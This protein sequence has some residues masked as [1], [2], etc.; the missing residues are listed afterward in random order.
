MTL[1]SSASIGDE[2]S[3][4]DYANSFDTYALT[5]GRNSHNIEGAAAD[6]TISVEG[7]GN[8]LVYVDSTKGWLLRNK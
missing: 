6:L 3:F 7:A 8:S 1:P 2:V 5:V 4:K